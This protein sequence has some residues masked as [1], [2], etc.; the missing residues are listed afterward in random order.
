MRDLR[1]FPRS[2]LWRYCLVGCE[3]VSL[4]ASQRYQT[5]YRSG[6]ITNKMQPCNRIY[7]STVYWRLNMFRGAHRSSSGALTV[8]EASS[9]H[10]HVVTGRSQVW[11]GTVFI[12]KNNQSKKDL[13]TL[14]DVDPDWD[15]TLTEGFPCFFLSCKANARVKPA[16]TGH[17]PHSS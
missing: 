12:F 16:K 6:E 2:W 8:F 3:A 15:S 4:G 13:T 14:E 7:Y 9:L 10:T 17:G 5:L 1:S 11:V